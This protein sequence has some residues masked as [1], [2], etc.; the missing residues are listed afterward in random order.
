MKRPC[1]PIIDYSRARCSCGK[2]NGA[3]R[4]YGES[5]GSF[6]HRAHES[7]KIHESAGQRAESVQVE[8]FETQQEMFLW[9]MKT[10]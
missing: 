4:D 10:N 5:V 1:V 8:M 3:A 2:W 9:R 7:F 6:T